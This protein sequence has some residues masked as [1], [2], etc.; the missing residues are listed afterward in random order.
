[1]LVEMEPA[2]D[3]TD[4]NYL[5][6]YVG[7][8]WVMFKQY[9]PEPQTTIFEKAF[10][11]IILSYPDSLLGTQITETLIND[12][13]DIPAKT[14]VIRDMIMDNIMEILTKMGFVLDGNYVEDKS[15]PYLT[16]L[17]D[18][19]YDVDGQSDI[20]GLGGV[21]DSQDIPAKERFIAGLE[22][23]Y[24]E[25]F[26][27]EQY[28]YIIEDISETAVKAIRDTLKQEDDIDSPAQHIVDR[29][30]KNKFAF[31]NTIA[32]THITSNGQIGSSPDSLFGYYKLEMDKLL[33][34]GTTTEIN[35]LLG[36]SKTD[37]LY[38]YGRNVIAL[39]LI[40][41]VNDSVLKDTVIR[42]LD[43]FVEDILT[44]NKLEDLLSKV[45]LNND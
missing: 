43:G 38:D 4:V 5:D 30:V 34:K 33:N 29:V 27:S 17:V 37:T 10:N 23:Y 24:G 25:G 3:L 14:K 36:S 26:N 39:F 13:L 8:I 7:E 18:F 20:V 11:L 2:V 41:D 31:E 44:I 15:L 35:T 19:V 45:V 42:Y 1:M 21:F 12:E 6:E 40:S 32:W 28:S 16:Q 9:I 22:C